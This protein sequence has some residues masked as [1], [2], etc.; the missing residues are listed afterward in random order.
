MHK[1]VK[2]YGHVETEFFYKFP[3]SNII[4]ISNVSNYAINKFWGQHMFQITILFKNRKC[5]WKCACIP[6]CF[7]IKKKHFSLLTYFNMFIGHKHKGLLI[8]LS[9]H[10]HTF[11]E[12]FKISYSN[13]GFVSV[14]KVGVHMIYILYPY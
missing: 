13:W 5:F 8:H 12:T 1:R 6:K 4:N 3:D 9:K 2:L 7:E 14:Q 11:I 10:F